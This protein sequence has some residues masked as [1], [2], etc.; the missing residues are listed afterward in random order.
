MSTKPKQGRSRVLISEISPLIEGGKY[1]VK[2][3]VNEALK[4]SATLVADGHDVLAGAVTWRKLG[5]KNW[6]TKALVLSENDRYH[7]EISFSEIGAQEYKFQAWIDYA[8]T[9]LHGL[10]K[11]FHDGQDVSVHLAD[12][13]KHLE[14]LEAQKVSEASKLLG[15]ID[16]DVLAAAEFALEPWLEEAFRKFPEKEF[17]T[18]S[19]SFPAYSDREKARFS[20]WYE[21]FPRSA[22]QEG[23]GSFADV[24]KLLPRVADLGFDVLYLPP[25][26]PIGEINRKGK[27]NSTVAQEGDVGSPWGIG[28]KEG[29]HKNIHPALGGIEDYKALIHKASHFGIEIA[30]DLAYQAAPDHPWVKEHPEWFKWRSDGTVQYAENPPKKYQDILPIYFESEDWENLWDELLSVILYWVSCGVKIFRVDNPHT[31]SIRFWE[32]AIAETQKL[33]P[34]VIFLAE[35]FTKPALMQAL[36]KVGF[37][38]GYSYYTWRNFR[39]ELIEYMGELTQGPEAEY[40]RPNFWPNT[41]DILPFNLQSG[42]ESLFMTRLF[43][44]GT[45]SSNYGVYGPVYEHLVHEAIPGK[46]EYHNSEKYEVQHHDW[47]HENKITWLMRALNRARKELKPL[48]QTRNFHYLEM[49]NQSL[50]AYLKWEGDEKVVCV[51]NLDPYNAHEGWLQLP[52]EFM[53]H[54]ESGY[55]MHDFISGAEYRWREEWNYVRLDPAR[56]FHLFKVMS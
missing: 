31:K 23:H 24:E 32:W 47:E 27:N 18:E 42:N 7:A 21:F 37:S 52:E 26:H 20:A 12:G 10:E 35:A 36:A 13:R 8:L 34:E 54:I 46:E 40:F 5:A 51:V 3:I 29:G 4:L 44:A 49:E 33:H 11:K 43:M 39:H 2:R 16:S 30:L 28:S 50:F 55:R 56:P 22:S 9:W 53:P 25:I 45:L 15:L 19:A 6:Q 48:Q 17:L 14:H 41:P 1:P 38:Q